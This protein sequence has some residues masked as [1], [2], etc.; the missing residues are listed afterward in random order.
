MKIE[1]K[2]RLEIRKLVF[3]VFSKSMG[4]G[5]GFDDDELNKKSKMAGWLDK[6]PTSR[7]LYSDVTIKKMLDDAILMDDWDIVNDIVNNVSFRK[8]GH[9]PKEIE[10]LGN[11]LAN[12][13]NESNWHKVSIARKKFNHYAL[14]KPAINENLLNEMPAFYPYNFTE[15]KTFDE[16]S[17]HPKL[18]KTD[19]GLKEWFDK[20]VSN[21]NLTLFEPHGGGY[22]YLISMKNGNFRE[23][24]KFN[25]SDS[26][27]GEMI[28][29]NEMETIPHDILTVL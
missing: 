22:S 27:R 19:L 28:R 2:I 6:K 11:S 10:D 24:F 1:N 3:E 4:L 14:N 15:I 20:Y 25:P 12:A 9:V 5:S 21:H 29:D 23:G 17:K 18:L 7:A 26:D 13:T 8:L 16:L